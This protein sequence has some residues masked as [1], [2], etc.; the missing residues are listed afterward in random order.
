MAITR[1]HQKGISLFLAVVVVT[2]ILSIMLG[3]TAILINQFKIMRGMGYSVA[4]YFAAETGVEQ[5]LQRYFKNAEPPLP[6]Y[7]SSG[8]T[9]LSNGATYF[10]DVVCC[11]KDSPGC[12]F[13][14]STNCP[15]PLQDPN[16]CYST[17]YCIRSAGTYKGTKRAI[18][19]QIL[20]TQQ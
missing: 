16:D 7:P 19:V 1:K 14:G 20:P 2:I 18:E 10:V 17:K 9:Q 13:Q 5:V 8:E 11:K 3:L 12:Y 15:P 6:R 4:A